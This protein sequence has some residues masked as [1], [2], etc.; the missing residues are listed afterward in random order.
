ML[1]WFKRKL[2]GKS[3]RLQFV[4]AVCNAEKPSIRYKELGRW[5]DCV[6]YFDDV[7]ITV[8]YYLTNNEYDVEIWNKRGQ[9]F[10]FYYDC[11]DFKPWDT[12][13]YLMDRY[14]LRPRFEHFIKSK[15]EESDRGYKSNKDLLDKYMGKD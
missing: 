4:E 15:Q 10:L 5:F 14:N 7:Q 6:L 9:E 8:K 3:K 1:N 11:L 12:I 2:F 13:D